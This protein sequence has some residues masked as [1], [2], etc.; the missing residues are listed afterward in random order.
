MEKTYII[1][2]RT[3][4]VNMLN[5]F[6]RNRNIQ[7]VPERLFDEMVNGMFDGTHYIVD[8]TILT[9]ISLTI[10]KLMLQLN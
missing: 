5:D 6:L 3:G 8:H 4:A 10:P 9:V 7:S 1:T 2:N